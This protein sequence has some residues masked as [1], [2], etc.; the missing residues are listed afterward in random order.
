MRPRV[1]LRNSLAASAGA[2]L[3]CA[4]AVAQVSTPGC[5][6]DLTGG[7]GPRDY[8]SQRGGL[9]TVERRH[10]TPKV[11]RLISGESTSKPGPDLA[12]T[13]SFFPNHHR[14][15]I[16]TTRLAERLKVDQVPDMKHSVACYYERALVFQPDDN[17]TRLLYARYLG[18]K[19]RTPDAATQ[20]NAA[21]RYAAPD[22]ALTH[23]NIG[24]VALEL[25][26]YDRALTHAHIA[27]RLGITQTSLKDA[28]V[29]AGKWT[30]PPAVAAASAASSPGAAAS[31][32]PGTAAPVAAAPAASAPARP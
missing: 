9:E 15:L 14:A 18:M 3:L 26:E 32:A 27:Y 24:L 28:L 29:K 8:R 19:G 10:F 23:Y 22:A 13:L 5:N 25:K 11:E 21:A 7:Y 31:A 12:Y 17:V 4:T 2:W 20:L 16:A 6:L 1:D 30:E